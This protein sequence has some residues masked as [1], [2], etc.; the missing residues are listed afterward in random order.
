MPNLRHK[1][2]QDYEFY[3]WLEKLLNH[4]ATGALVFGPEQLE[5]IPYL[6]TTNPE[7]GTRYDWQKEARRAAFFRDAQSRLLID[8]YGQEYEK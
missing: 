5:K 2:M 3:D 4:L 8:K 7:T 6:R 1:Y